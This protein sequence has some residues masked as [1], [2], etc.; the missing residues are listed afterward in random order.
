[1]DEM[2]KI[3]I[4]ASCLAVSAVAGSG[5]VLVSSIEQSYK[6]VRYLEPI[7]YCTVFSTSEDNYTAVCNRRY[8]KIVLNFTVNQSDTYSSVADELRRGARLEELARCSILPYKAPVFDDLNM[9]KLL[10]CRIGYSLNCKNKDDANYFS[11]GDVNIIMDEK[12]ES[13]RFKDLKG[14]CKR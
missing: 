8:P 12:S 11:S 6:K 1:V 2:Q 7:P 9:G 4:V 13:Y 10:G 3:G 5:I 14:A